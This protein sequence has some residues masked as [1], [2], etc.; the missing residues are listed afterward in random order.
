M[1]DYNSEIEEGQQA[2]SKINTKKAKHRPIIVRLQKTKGEQQVLTSAGVNTHAC[3]ETTL[4]L[5]FK[6]TYGEPEKHR[7]TLFRF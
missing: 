2:L 7:M 3:R 5:T 1:K 4:L 6:R